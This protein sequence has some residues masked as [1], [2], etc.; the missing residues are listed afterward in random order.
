MLWVKSTCF[1]KI[2]FFL[3]NM[4]SLYLIRSVHSVF[5]PIEIFKIFLK[6]ERVSLCLFRLVEADFRPTET[7]ISSFLK[8][9][10]G[11]FQSHY[12]NF[13]F[14]FLSLRVGSWLHQSIFVVFLQYFCK[15][16]VLRSRYVLFALLFQVYFLISCIFHAFSWV[17]RHL[18]NYWGFWWFKPI[19]V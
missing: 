5:R 19:L 10:I 13:F 2:V 3:K 1:S 15:V 11:L 18:Q 9:R 4:V 17:F 16:F 14:S 12:S 7:R 8:S 6:F